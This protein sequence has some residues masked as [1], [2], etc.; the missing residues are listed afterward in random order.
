MRL[1]NLNILGF[2]VSTRSVQEIVSESLNKRE[3]RVVNTINPH[4][5]AE[6]KRDPMFH[7]ALTE[8][9][10]LIPDGSGIVLVA[11]KLHKAQVSKISGSDLFFETMRQLNEKSGSVFFLGSTNDVL[12]KISKHSASEFPNVKVHTLSPPYKA[13]FSND[14]KHAF[15]DAINKS[16]SD[17]IFVGLTAPKQEKLIEAI[18]TEIS[19]SM[20][21]GIGAVFDFY[22]GTVKRPSKI[23][24]DLHLEWLVRLIGEPKRLWQRTFVSAPIFLCDMY[25]QK[26]LGF[27]N[28]K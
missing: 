1:Q 26:Y 10:E 3:L 15:V 6:S 4:S 8:S 17:V 27:K 5:Y 24:L 16:Q 21:S 12:E 23:W 7:K 25:R 14:D 28:E 2:S 18:K 11:R 13:E 22:A 19:G 9:T 20:I